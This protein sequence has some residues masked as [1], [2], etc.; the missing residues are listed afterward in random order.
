MKLTRAADV[1][2]A[3]AS[4][5]VR[6]MLF[7]LLSEHGKDLRRLP[8][9]KRRARLEAFF[10]TSGCPVELSG[11]IDGDVRHI[12]ESAEELGLEGVM[13]KRTDGRYVGQRSRS[14]LKLK[15]ERTQEVVVGG[16]RPGKGGRGQ[17]VGSLLLGIPDGSKLRYVGPGGQRLQHPR[18]QG[19]PAAARCPA[20]EDLPVRGRA[21]GRRLGRALGERQARRGG[22]LRGMDRQ[23]QAPAPGVARLAAG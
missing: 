16:W 9:S 15:F 17:S 23:R 20:P 3:Q 13:A 6:L 18:A 8:L 11:L 5:P 22:H 19:T 4:T 10:T 7:D 12:L 14:W 1:A 21:G 2:K